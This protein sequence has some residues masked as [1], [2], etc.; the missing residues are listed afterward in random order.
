LGRKK[1][2]QRGSRRWL[3]EDKAAS[4]IGPSL[5]KQIQQPAVAP[6]H[7][8]EEED[9]EEQHPCAG[10]MEEEEPTQAT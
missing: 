6:A 2:I 10:E 8:E 3:R 7:L 1:Q 9:D 5:G 4:T